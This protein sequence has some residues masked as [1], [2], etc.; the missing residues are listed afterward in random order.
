MSTSLLTPKDAAARLAISVQQL[1]DLTDDGLLRWVNIGRGNKRPTRR[2]TE[3]DL[4]E[5]IER[6]STR[7]Q[8]IKKQV[9]KPIRMT[10]SYAAVDLQA[11]RAKRQ[12]EKQ[13]S[14]KTNNGRRL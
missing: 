4:D 9:A 3:V 8:S 7:C 1:K 12:S 10:S 11:I 14:T 13:S 5:F 2:Y 6:R